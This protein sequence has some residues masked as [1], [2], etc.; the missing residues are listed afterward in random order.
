[1]EERFLCIAQWTCLWCH[2]NFHWI[3]FVHAAYQCYIKV[4]NL[5]I[6]IP[7]GLVTPVITIATS[8]AAP[9]SKYCQKYRQGTSTQSFWDARQTNNDVITPKSKM[10]ILMIFI[11]PDIVFFVHNRTQW[12]G[13]FVLCWGVGGVQSLAAAFLLPASLSVFLSFQPLF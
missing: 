5:R 8:I 13:C 9:Y 12:R 4:V 6:S 11:F 7:V 1:M 10:L 2:A 3:R